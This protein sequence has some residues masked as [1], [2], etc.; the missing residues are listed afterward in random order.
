VHNYG[1]RA[2]RLLDFPKAVIHIINTHD[3]TVRAR[4][5]IPLARSG[6]PVTT[7]GWAV[8]SAVRGLLF[9]PRHAGIACAALPEGNSRNVEDV[10]EA[11][12][13]YCSFHVSLPSESKRSYLDCIHFEQGVAG[14]VVN[15]LF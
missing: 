6:R 9:H 4:P 3:E 15:Q 13:P 7:R 8:L 5:R 11:F 1:P 2:V 10:Q 12:G 14:N